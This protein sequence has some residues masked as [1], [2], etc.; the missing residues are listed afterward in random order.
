MVCFSVLL[1]FLSNSFNLLHCGLWYHWFIHIAGF[2]IISWRIIS[3]LYV[4]MGSFPAFN[5]LNSSSRPL[6]ARLFF[7]YIEY[8]SYWTCRNFLL[9]L[10]SGAVNL[11]LIYDLL[12]RKLLYSFMICSGRLLN[13]LIFVCFL[14][15]GK[16]VGVILK[17]IGRFGLSF[18][19]W[20]GKW[21]NYFE[22]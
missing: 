18:M 20:Q 1:H 12:A 11:M 21:I 7:D 6:V 10:V 16:F 8:A 9:W 14:G 3:L 22:R 2:C 19:C 17:S 4:R 5:K 13:S 15:R